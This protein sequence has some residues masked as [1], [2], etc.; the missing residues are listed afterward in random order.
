MFNGLIKPVQAYNFEIASKAV[1]N[2]IG[3]VP[4]LMTNPT[5]KGLV[6]GCYIG[7]YI[8]LINDSL[9]ASREFYLRK[10]LK[11]PLIQ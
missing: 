5:R 9:E 3:K 8:R 1:A 7:E 4:P 2:K 11:E 6:K 10:N